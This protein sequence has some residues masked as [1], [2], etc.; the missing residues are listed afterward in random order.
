[1][2]RN[3]CQPEKEK[4]SKDFHLRPPLLLVYL[5]LVNLHGGPPSTDSTIPRC[6][7]A[8]SEHGQSGLR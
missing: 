8:V 2:I 6:Q 1:M 5:L 3:E 7:R 4:G